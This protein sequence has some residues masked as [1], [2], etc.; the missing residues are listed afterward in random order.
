MAPAGDLHIVV[1]RQRERREARSDI[2]LK[3]VAIFRPTAAVLQWRDIKEHQVGV[4]RIKE[5]SVIGIERVPGRVI[6]LDQIIEIICALLLCQ[7]RQT[8]RT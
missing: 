5:T 6:P 8:Q 4:L 2:L 3:V 1:G 7:R